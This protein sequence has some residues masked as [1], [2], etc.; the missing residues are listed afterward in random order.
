M[1]KAPWARLTRF[2]SP[3][4]TASPQARMNSTIP[5]ATPS[6]RTVSMGCL[7]GRALGRVADGGD[8]RELDIVELAVHAFAAADIDVLDDVAGL[9]VDLDRA[10]RAFPLHALRGVDQRGAAGAGPG[11]GEHLG[12]QRHAVI[13]ADGHE[14]RPHV[15][16][17][18]LESGDEALV[19][20]AVMGGG[21]VLRG[22]DPE[23]D[24]ADAV[25]Q[26]V[27]EHVAEGDQLDAGVLQ[28]ALGELL[29]ER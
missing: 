24:V 9:P 1:A 2:I 18:G 29:H 10:A 21:V 19:F 26:V 4:V 7:A 6:N 27:I 15:V 11:L 13:A 22:D 14:V 28:A 12:D 3:S 20:G 16:G 23:R 17:G 5:Y 8:G 25:E